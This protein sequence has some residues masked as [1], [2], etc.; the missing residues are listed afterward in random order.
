LGSR[1]PHLRREL[2][3]ARPTPIR[4]LVLV[5]GHLAGASSDVNRAQL[6]L[7]P[8]IVEL[9]LVLKLEQ[10]V[11]RALKSKFLVQAPVYSCLHGLGTPRMTAA[12]VRPVVR[13][14]PLRRRAA[15]QQQLAALVEDEQRESAMQY[16]PPLVAAP[17]AHVAH[18]P[19]RLVHQDERIAL[20]RGVV[21]G[22]QTRLRTTCLPHAGTPR[23]RAN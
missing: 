23:R 9:R 17:L 3:R 5:D 14:Q 19:V 8:D 13:P 15:L 10:K 7:G 20:R 18:L 6:M 4:D 16:A 2:L 11:Q 22:P 21:A 12:A 1:T